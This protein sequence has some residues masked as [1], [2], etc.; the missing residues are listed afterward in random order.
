MFAVCAARLQKPFL[1]FL[2]SIHLQ[3]WTE[4]NDGPPGI[5]SFKLT[6]SVTAGNMIQGSRVCREHR[7]TCTRVDRRHMN[8]Q[9]YVAELH[10]FPLII[11]HAPVPLSLCLCVPKWHSGIFFAAFTK[12]TLISNGP[13]DCISCEGCK[14]ESSPV[15]GRYLLLIRTGLMISTLRHICEN[16]FKD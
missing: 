6:F 5:C 7:Q 11:T 4:K 16:R 10:F 1:L 9:G 12:I 2:S 14:R 3:W 15:T 8:T 13:K